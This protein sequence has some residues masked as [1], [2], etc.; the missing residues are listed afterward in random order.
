MRA[1]PNGLPDLGRTSSY[2]GVRAD[3]DIFPD[4]EGLV[5]PNTEGM[6]VTPDD[7]R[8]MRQDRIPAE[9]GGT[10]KHPLFAL[11]TDNLG[12]LL[13][14]RRDPTNPVRHAF[15]EPAH[16]MTF[17]SYLQAIHAT[18]AFWQRVT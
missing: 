11:D 13:R 16:P 5:Y 8:R 17:L 15:V 18:A 14:V 4:D 10:G 1:D 2:L 7:W 12:P 3:Y 6:S 9:L